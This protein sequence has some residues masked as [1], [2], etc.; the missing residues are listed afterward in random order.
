MTQRDLEKFEDSITNIAKE[1]DSVLFI[2]KNRHQEGILMSV[3]LANTNKELV[4][5][6]ESVII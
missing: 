3:M 5:G 4:I 6:M 1:Q 2:Y